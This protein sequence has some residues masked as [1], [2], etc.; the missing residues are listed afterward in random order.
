M[1][2]QDNNLHVAE[3]KSFIAGVDSQCTTP[4]TFSNLI[5]VSRPP[6]LEPKLFFS[7]VIQIPDPPYPTH[8][9]SNP[10][11]SPSRFNSSK[12]PITHS[13]LLTHSSRTHTH[14]H[15][16]PSHP[17]NNHHL[18]APIA[19]FMGKNNKN[20]FRAFYPYSMLFTLRIPCLRQTSTN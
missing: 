18:L 13:H 14:I 7:S 6:K 1:K 16:A 17:T 20:T 2:S 19:P 15:T 12:T 8:H 3:I 11:L 5:S 9:D 4:S 10:P